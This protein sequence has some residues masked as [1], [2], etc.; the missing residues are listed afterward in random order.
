MN[1]N[2]TFNTSDDDSLCMTMATF[3]L[4]VLWY[5]TGICYYKMVDSIKMNISIF[6][7]TWLY[8]RTGAWFLV[9]ILL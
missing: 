9:F 8:L 2:I 6:S 7:F 5:S 1:T 4:F 3:R